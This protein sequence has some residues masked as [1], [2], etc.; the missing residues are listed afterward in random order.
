MAGE[1]RAAIKEDLIGQN[2]RSKYVIE[3]I[4]I[5]MAELM[6]PKKQKPEQHMPKDRKAAEAGAVVMDG[7]PRLARDRV[8]ADEDQGAAAVVVVARVFQEVA[9]GAVV[10]AGRNSLLLE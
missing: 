3:L 10:A 2:C 8:G 9:L 7:G 6:T 1:A 4:L 5:G